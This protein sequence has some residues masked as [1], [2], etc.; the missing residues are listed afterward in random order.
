[1][2][3]DAKLCLNLAF[4][5]LRKPL[6]VFSIIEDDKFA[7][8]APESEHPDSSSQ[9]PKTCSTSPERCIVQGANFHFSAALG[10]LLGFI[11]D[12]THS[13]FFEL[14]HKHSSENQG[15]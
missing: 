11:H 15:R 6:G 1:L 3:F 14:R 8:L 10:A 7:T 5:S 13:F 9:A 2:P 12:S 4:H